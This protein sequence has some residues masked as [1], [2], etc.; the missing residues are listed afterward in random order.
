MSSRIPEA[1]KLCSIHRPHTADFTARERESTQLLEGTAHAPSIALSQAPSDG[2]KLDGS[3]DAED[4]AS[5]NAS[6]ADLSRPYYPLNVQHTAQEEHDQ[7]RII[8]LK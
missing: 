8:V 4:N 2:S 7:E 3:S 1:F 5:H 6:H